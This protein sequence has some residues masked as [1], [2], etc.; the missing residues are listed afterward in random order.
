MNNQ[1]DSQQKNSQLKNSQPKNRRQTKIR[2]KHIKFYNS[3]SFKLTVIVFLSFAVTN[4]ISSGIL[5]QV[6]RPRVEGFMEDQLRGKLLDFERIYNELGIHPNEAAKYFADPSIEVRVCSD[7]REL[8]EEGLIS[9]EGAL[10]VDKGEAVNLP[11]DRDRRL[12]CSIGKIGNQVVVIS[13]HVMRNFASQFDR[14]QK[15]FILITMLLGLMLV[16]LVIHLAVKRIK[17]VNQGVTEIAGGNFDILLPEMGNDEM[18]ELSHNFNIMAEE[19]RSNEYLHKEFVSSVSHEFKTPIA[20]MKGYAKALKEQTLSEEKRSQYLDILIEESGRLSNLAT[21]LLRISELNHVVIQKQF[22]TIQLDEQIRD[23]LIRLQNKW[24][25]KDLNLELELDEIAY[26]CDEELLHNVWYN[27]LI[28]AIKF[29]PT[30]GTLWITLKQQNTH[31]LFRVKDEG[32]GIAEEDQERIFHNFYKVD[33]S[34]NTE[35]NGL[36]LPLALKIVQLHEGTI[37]VE[38]E[39]GRGASFIVELPGH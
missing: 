13:P 6:E 8:V 34:R 33:R 24:E 36:G 21:N 10:K 26:S 25:E 23:I 11:P 22:Q 38:S 4:L 2:N 27:L 29:S 35:G 15:L 18:S 7:V 1:T 39:P 16:W 32:P 30:G 17:K 5:N 28:N 37:R 9:E 3:I 31:I 20:S 12:P 14:Y 19:L